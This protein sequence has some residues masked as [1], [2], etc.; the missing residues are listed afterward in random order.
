MRCVTLAN[1]AQL[2]E[3]R[4]DSMKIEFRVKTILFIK[5]ETLI[6]TRICFDEEL[7]IKI[8]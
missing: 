5:L 7:I 6:V 8:I 4:I 3:K 2:N 1:A